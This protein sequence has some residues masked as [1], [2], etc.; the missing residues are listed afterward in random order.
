MAHPR[1]RRWKLDFDYL[2]DL[3]PAEHAWHAQF[4]DEYYAGDHRFAEP[5]LAAD[6]P[7]KEIG[8][9]K[10]ANERDVYAWAAAV[11]GIQLDGLL[12]PQEPM[13][14]DPLPQY[15][16]AD[17]YRAVLREYRA[18]IDQPKPWSPAAQERIGLLQMYMQ[19]MAQAEC[20]DDNDD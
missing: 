1:F 17:D 3:T 6:K 20:G 8:L 4:T 16:T 5:L 14:A 10:R 18:A 15:L 2:A 11:G 19:S 13:S 7:R 9:D 12:P